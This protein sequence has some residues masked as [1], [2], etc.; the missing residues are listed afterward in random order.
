MRLS[1]PQRA[2]IEGV[3]GQGSA[4][5]ARLPI[6]V[7]EQHDDGGPRIGVQVRRLRGV[8]EVRAGG[9]EG[10]AGLDVDL[11]GAEGRHVET[12]GNSELAEERQ[13]R[14]AAGQNEAQ[15][16]PVGNNELGGVGW[17]VCIGRAVREPD[18]IRRNVQRAG[19]PLSEAFHDAGNGLDI[20]VRHDQQIDAAAARQLQIEVIGTGTQ[21]HASTLASLQ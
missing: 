16:R 9:A 2:D 3:A 4:Q 10:P 21:L 19:T 5:D 14:A 12:A 18:G 1:T 13:F 7:V 20:R 11:I 6:V 17:G 15:L 8:R